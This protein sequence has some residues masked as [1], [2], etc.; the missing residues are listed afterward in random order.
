MKKLS[1]LIS[2]LILS[3]GFTGLSQAQTTEEAQSAEAPAIEATEREARIEALRRELRTEQR[4]LRESRRSEIESRLEGLTE[5]E[6]EA[7]RE[8]R[9]MRMEA[10]QRQ[11]RSASGRTRNCQCEDAE[12]S[13]N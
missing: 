12:N 7:L 6:R 8:R 2:C 13:A 3:T 10:H 5:D 4:S 11:Q 9:Q 1:I